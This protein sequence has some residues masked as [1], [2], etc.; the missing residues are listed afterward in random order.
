M[1]AFGLFQRG[2]IESVSCHFHEGMVGIILLFLNSSLNETQN[3]RYQFFNCFQS[4]V[5]SI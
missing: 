4:L 1:V 5:T 3:E 2:M